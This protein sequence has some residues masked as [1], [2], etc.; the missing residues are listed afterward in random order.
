MDMKTKGYVAISAIVTGCVLA[1]S[2]N[3]STTQIVTGVFFGTLLGIYALPVL[4]K[5]F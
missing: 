5:M 1:L 4:R 3:Y 2:G